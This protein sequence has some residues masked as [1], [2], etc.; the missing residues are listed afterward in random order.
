MYFKSEREYREIQHEVHQLQDVVVRLIEIVQ[1]LVYRVDNPPAPPNP[2]TKVV[3]NF[4]PGE[5]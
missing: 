5:K 2:A 3:I 1:A 4:K